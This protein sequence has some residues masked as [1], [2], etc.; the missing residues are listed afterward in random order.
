MPHDPSSEQSPA[1][2]AAWPPL[3]QLEW[4]D[5]YATL[6]LFT[7]VVGK[8]RL[9]QT[10]WI[11][12]SW[13]VSLAVSPRGLT[14]GWVPHGDEALEIEFDFLSHTLEVS[15]S[16]G[17]RRSFGLEGISVAGFY[18]ELME[19]LDEMGVPV[20]IVETPNEMEEITPFPEDEEHATYD[21]DA[22]HRFWRILLATQRVFTRFRS[23]F[24][25]KVSPVHFFWGA[26]DL[27]VSRF[28]GETAPEHPGGLPHFPD[29][30]AREAY[31]H[32]VS[33]AGFWPGNAGGPVEEASYYSYIYPA[34]EGYGEADVSPDAAYWT[35]EL[36]EWVLPYEAVRTAEDPEATLMEFLQST[37]EAAAD[38]AGWDRAALEREEGRP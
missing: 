19:G 23:R 4:R 7:Q 31:S 14:T 26:F 10:P 8:V 28:S 2:A 6:H 16:R 9:V 17:G 15:T 3:S 20:D 18:R 37:Y 33:S 12:H 5:T 35:D 25:G 32:E 22:A 29:P 13:S 30:V 34:P 21:P 36:G 27:A 24:L 1:Q 11:N 38:L